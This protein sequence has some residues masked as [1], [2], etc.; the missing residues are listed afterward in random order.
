[1]TVV[2]QAS[3]RDEVPAFFPAGRETL[4]G[5]FTRPTV[6]PIGVAAIALPGGGGTRLS[7]NR[8]RVWF[9]LCRRLA[10]EGYHALRCDYH[11]AGESTG[12]EESLRLDRPFID[13]VEGAVRWVEGQGV[14]DLVLIG[15][16]F[17]AR[18][19]LSYAATAPAVRGLVLISAPVLDYEEGEATV[20]RLAHEW[21]I[22]KY[23]R[24]SLRPRTL[25]GL[26]D[27]D[28]RRTYAKVVRAKLRVVSGKRR[29]RWTRDDAAGAGSNFLDPLSALVERKVPMLFIHGDGDSIH[30]EFTQEKA[31]RLGKLLERAGRVVEVRTVP[32][33]VHG[34]TTVRSQ[35]SVLDLIVDWLVRQRDALSV[36]AS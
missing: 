19:A 24:R 9:R 32:D 15:S 1:M 34:F 28:R 6:D 21:S 16:C 18:T 22:W 8:N 30:R 5:V 2:Q 35:D 4:F 29:G 20:T 10:G 7:T 26:L 36:G 14:S 23:L 25:K 31:G 33:P 13:D 17:G 27:R 11:G 12:K 3:S